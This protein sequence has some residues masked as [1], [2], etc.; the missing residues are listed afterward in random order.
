MAHVKLYPEN[1][2][3]SK[4]IKL[5]LMESKT[6]LTKVCKEHDLNYETTHKR[7]HQSKKVDLEF[8]MDFI[9]MVNPEAN[10]SVDFNMSLVV[11]GKEI[12]NQKFNK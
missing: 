12:F 4:M 10:L 6:N 5:F 7:L 9:K 11:N 1:G 2:D 8:L 3:I